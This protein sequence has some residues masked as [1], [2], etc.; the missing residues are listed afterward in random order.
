MACFAVD[1]H[2]SCPAALRGLQARLRFDAPS[3]AGCLLVAGATRQPG[4]GAAQGP[5]MTP[6]CRMI[7][8]AP[9]LVLQWL[10]PGLSLAQHW[11]PQVWARLVAVL[12]AAVLPSAGA[13]PP[14]SPLLSAH[15]DPCEA[16]CR[17]DMDGGE[18]RY[19]TVLHLH[20]ITLQYTDDT[21]RRHSESRGPPA[22]PQHRPR[23]C[24]TPAGHQAV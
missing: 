23:S 5:L 7:Q 24:Q 22:R 1:A 12:P 2:P 21:C 3:L 11:A 16:R 13:P 18:H 19:V 10:H 17:S 6:H 9:H 8:H 15:T 20:Y 4:T 14:S